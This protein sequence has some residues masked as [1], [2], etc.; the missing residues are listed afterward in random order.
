MACAVPACCLCPRKTRKRPRLIRGAVSSSALLQ[1]L[2]GWWARAAQEPLGCLS[3]SSWARGANAALGRLYWL[4]WAPL[5]K[6]KTKPTS[7]WPEFKPPQDSWHCAGGAWH[8]WELWHGTCPLPGI[9]GY[10]Q[11]TSR[12]Q[13]GYKQVTEVPY[14]L[15]ARGTNLPQQSESQWFP[16]LTAEQNVE[17]PGS[18]SSAAFKPTSNPCQREHIFIFTSLGCLEIVLGQR[19]LVNV[20]EQQRICQSP[21]QLLEPS[22]PQFQ[23]YRLQPA[24]LFYDFLRSSLLLEAWDGGKPS[25]LGPW[26]LLWSLALTG[27]MRSHLHSSQ[28]LTLKSKVTFT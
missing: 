19:V 6:N 4:H 9:S 2:G 22:T 7:Q 8:W 12:L 27:L 14:G 25:S 24:S 28:H 21:A 13:T 20:C 1:L 10:K 15:I 3:S 26:A 17:E 23:K 5:E 11:V 18:W 16:R